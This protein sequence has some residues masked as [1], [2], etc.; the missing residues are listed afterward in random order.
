MIIRWRSLNYAWMSNLGQVGETIYAHGNEVV[1]VFLIWLGSKLDSMRLL[2][3]DCTSF[4][5]CIKPQLTHPQLL[6][7][8]KCESQIE[9]SRRT[10][11]RSMFPGSQHYRRVEGRARALGGEVGALLVLGRATSN[12]DTQDSPRPGLGGSHHLPP[13]SIL[14]TTPR[15]PHPNGHFVLGL[16]SGSL[17]SLS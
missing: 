17:N 1:V 3:N 4:V 13:Y 11:S 15:G 14:C 2:G 10:R 8:L 9:N 5:A 7:G 16:P 6:A 12:S